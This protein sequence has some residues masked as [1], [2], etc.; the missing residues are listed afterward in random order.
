MSQNTVKDVRTWR[1]SKMPEWAKDSVRQELIQAALRWPSEARPHHLPFGFGAHDS[2]VGSVQ[3]GV[4]WH[5]EGGFPT[6]FAIRLREEDELP[7]YRHYRTK[8]LLNDDR[9]WSINYPRGPWF[10]TEKDARLH[11]L[12]E[13][14]EEF[15]K[16]L[17]ALSEKVQTASDELPEQL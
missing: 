8:A 9:P 7:A 1:D 12:W 6:K 2:M 4:Y 16:T 5:V 11:I 10:R 3:P 15:S 17:F 14:C 13:R